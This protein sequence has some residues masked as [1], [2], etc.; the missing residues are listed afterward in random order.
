MQSAMLLGTLKKLITLLISDDRNR[1]L[2]KL[3]II[4]KQN[5]KLASSSNVVDEKKPS[6]LYGCFRTLKA[7]TDDL[8]D[9][10]TLEL[11]FV[12]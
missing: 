5:I 3:V 10:M 8:L 2:M 6:R 11:N 7:T 9:E 4:P 12:W 1:Y